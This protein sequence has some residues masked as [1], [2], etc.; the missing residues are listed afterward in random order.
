MRVEVI[1]SNMAEIQ[2]NSIAVGEVLI[3]ISYSTPVACHIQGKGFFKTAVKRSQTTTRHINKWI[4]SHGSNL[5]LAE[6]KPQEWFEN[7][8][9]PVLCG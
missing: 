7:I 2:V 3:L 4:R 9:Q 1:G 5:L 8:L 6:E